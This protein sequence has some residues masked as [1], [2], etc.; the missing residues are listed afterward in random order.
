M[1][2]YRTPPQTPIQYATRGPKCPQQLRLT[3]TNYS[4]IAIG[5]ELFNITLK[6]V[7]QAPVINIRQLPRPISVQKG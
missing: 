5:I 6:V 4:N 1:Q 3:T 7:I 2:G